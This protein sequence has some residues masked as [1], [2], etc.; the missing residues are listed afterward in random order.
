MGLFFVSEIAPGCF[1]IAGAVSSL[2]WAPAVIVAFGALCWIWGWSWVMSQ[3]R[4]WP[5][6]HTDA[7]TQY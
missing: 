5:E 3:A 1:F 6:P 2:D 4:G 7:S